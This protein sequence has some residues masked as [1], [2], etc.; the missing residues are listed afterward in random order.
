[1]KLTVST[2]LHCSGAKVLS[3][4][5]GPETKVQDDIDPKHQHPSRKVPQHCFDR[6]ARRVERF[7]GEI[8][9][10]QSRDPLIRCQAKRRTLV[11]NLPC[12]S[13]LSGTR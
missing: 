10:E 11:L 12:K 4:A 1:M 13:G 8:V 5:A 2:N 9:T 6:V 7:L 3:F